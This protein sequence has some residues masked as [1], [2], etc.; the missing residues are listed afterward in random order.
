MSTTVQSETDLLV[1]CLRVLDLMAEQRSTYD[2]LC[3][4][5]QDFSALAAAL[6]MA[7]L[8]AMGEPDTIPAQMTADRVE[9]QLEQLFAAASVILHAYTSLGEE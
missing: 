8:R 7:D 1:S 6:L 3:R 4:Q 5:T 9:E 2:R